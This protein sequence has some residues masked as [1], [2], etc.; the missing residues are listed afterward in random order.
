[1]NYGLRVW[2]QTNKIKTPMDFKKISTAYATMAKSA[3][4]FPNFFE[5]DPKLSLV[6]ISLPKPNVRK[7]NYCMDDVCQ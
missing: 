2:K 1:L 4:K 6:N 5:R 7:N 3:Q